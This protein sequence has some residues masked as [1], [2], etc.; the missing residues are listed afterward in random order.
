MRTV[1]FVCCHAK[2]C[3]ASTNEVSW[4]CEDEVC[5][6]A[7][8][9]DDNVTLAGEEGLKCD[10][11]LTVTERVIKSDRRREQATAEYNRLSYSP[12]LHSHAHLYVPIFFSRQSYPRL[13]TP[14]QMRSQK[15]SL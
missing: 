6:A 14:Q 12:F 2:H 5:C 10:S 1:K 4:F 11:D 15:P 13:S 9:D 7:E 3:A 8:D